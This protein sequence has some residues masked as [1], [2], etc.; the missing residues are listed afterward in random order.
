[1]ITGVDPVNKEEANRWEAAGWLA[2]DI[3]S[4]GVSKA[5]KVGKFRKGA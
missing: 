2:L 3:F 4:F 1:M 5:G